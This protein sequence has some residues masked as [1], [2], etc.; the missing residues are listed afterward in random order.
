MQQPPPPAAPPAASNRRR[1][2]AVSL[3]L[4]P[5]ASREKLERNDAPPVTGGAYDFERATSS[6]AGKLMSSPKKV[7][8]VETG[9]ERRKKV[10]GERRSR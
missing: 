5:P 6:L 2:N 7:T 9:K 4:C 1:A 10:G 3:R 8:I